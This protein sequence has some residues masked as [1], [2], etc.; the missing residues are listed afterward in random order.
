MFILLSLNMWVDG[1]DVTTEYSQAEKSWICKNLSFI[2][3]TLFIWIVYKAQVFTNVN[4]NLRD[5]LNFF[6][7][8]WIVLTII[9]LIFTP[10]HTWIKFSS[11]EKEDISNNSIHYI[12][13]IMMIFFFVPISLALTIII[14]GILTFIYLFTLQHNRRF[15]GN[16]RQEQTITYEKAMET[17]KHFGASQLGGLKEGSECPIC[18][19]NYE[20]QEKDGLDPE[21][22]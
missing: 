20:Q 2:S 17:I 16:G 1:Q 3:V 18:L 12:K 11:F 6:D 14:V 10:I 15:H 5:L 19:E 7:Y 8:F 9:Y 13:S 4:R 21:I 22:V